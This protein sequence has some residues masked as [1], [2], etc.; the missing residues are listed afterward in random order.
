VV[1]KQTGVSG[2]SADRDRQGGGQS[3]PLH[4]EVLLDT[5]SGLKR[6]VLRTRTARQFLIDTIGR[7]P[8]TT[9]GGPPA[10]RIRHS[11]ILNAIQ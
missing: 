7:P 2:A 5:V 10:Y 6:E 1:P 9:T 11:P 4:L 3:R 8:F